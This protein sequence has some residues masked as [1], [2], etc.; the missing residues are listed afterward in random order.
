[1][2]DGDSA[3]GYIREAV[4][5][6]VSKLGIG[7]IHNPALIA[8]LIAI[9]FA[10]VVKVPIL[11]ATH[12]K[13]DFAKMISTGGMPSSH[14]AAVSSL[15]AVI[16]IR[17]GPDSGLFAACVVFAIIVMYDAAGIRRHAGEQAI[18][19]NKLEAEI[20]KYIEKWP[21]GR[22]EAYQKRL[23]EMLG[24]QPIEVFAGCVVG[25]LIGALT[26]YWMRSVG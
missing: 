4:R 6:W 16:G 8:A 19:I 15:A 18:A 9:V 24:H 13:W 20:G 25:I 14:S 1:M 5:V 17:N 11:F 22:H 21:F 3:L 12:R 2:G 23:K 26:A 7:I 10:Q